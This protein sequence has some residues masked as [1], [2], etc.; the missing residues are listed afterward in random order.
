ML[1]RWLLVGFTW[2]LLVLPAPSTGLADEV[3]DIF[4]RI[5]GA[6]DQGMF[7]RVRGASDL[8]KAY[9][10][11]K[12]PAPGDLE[13]LLA[14]PVVRN[15][16]AQAVISLMGRNM[17][18]EDGQPSA[19]FNPVRL[20]QLLEVLIETPSTP[21]A[22]NQDEALAIKIRDEMVSPDDRLASGLTSMISIYVLAQDP[23]SAMKYYDR[24]QALPKK[25][26][27]DLRRAKA[28]QTLVWFYCWTGDLLSAINIYSDLACLDCSASIQIIQG[29]T[30]AQLVKAL[31]GADRLSEAARYY[32]ELDKQT[33][34]VHVKKHK[35]QAG[36]AL[37][38][39]YRKAGDL[40][41]AD[42]LD[43]WIKAQ[44]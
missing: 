36:R 37:A 7:D 42:E 41:A 1:K 25:S 12:D 39:G 30:L 28:I 14:E 3:Q 15:Y 43:T 4:D 18:Y 27:L 19:S 21:P 26:M 8:I 16:G 44:K 31:A 32:S 10:A 38:A 20:F 6:S 9:M 23:D 13:N 11:I 35:V 2:A 17:R 40:K 24:L 29:E 34:D 33:L 5:L 22:D